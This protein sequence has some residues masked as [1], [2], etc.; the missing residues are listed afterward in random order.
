MATVTVK[1]LKIVSESDKAGEICSV[2]FT[3]SIECDKAEQAL[4]KDGL[5]KFAIR[6]SLLGYDDWFD[7]HLRDLPTGT[8]FYRC[9][10]GEIKIGPVVMPCKVLDEDV[11]EDE[12][13]VRV[14]A[15]SVGAPGGKE[16]TAEGS[17]DSVT[18]D[19]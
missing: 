8:D 13:Y 11:G 6:A 19:L 15:T 16:Y 7:D 10:D 4:S 2:S 5:L 12:I 3:Y 18:L 14:T 17:S 9:G 1:D